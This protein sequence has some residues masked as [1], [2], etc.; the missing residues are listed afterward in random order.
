M[1]PA[2]QEIDVHR[3][4]VDEAFV[5][6][7][8]AIRDARGFGAQELR[9]IVGKGN[10]SKDKAPVLKPAIISELKKCDACHSFLTSLRFSHVYR[11]HIDAAA[12]SKNPGVLIVKLPAG[13]F[14]AAPAPATTSK[15]WF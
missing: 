14:P 13:Q 1:N 2:P 3:L 15:G 10:H 12:D 6:V 7:R 4:T 5:Q 8:K 11:L 9:I